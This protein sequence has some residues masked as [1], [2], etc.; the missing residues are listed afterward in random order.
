[1]KKLCVFALVMMSGVAYAQNDEWD[2]SYIRFDDR[3]FAARARIDPK[4]SNRFCDCITNEV[5]RVGRSRS[6][7]SVKQAV[8]QTCAH[9]EQV[10]REA[11]IREGATPAQAR[12]YANHG[13][14]IR[15]QAALP[16]MVPLGNGSCP[17]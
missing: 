3:L 6:F 4:D 16:P 9:Q 15:I 10:Y 12:G 7:A 13:K 2:D 5:E 14:R 17:L 11:L 1:M 8:D